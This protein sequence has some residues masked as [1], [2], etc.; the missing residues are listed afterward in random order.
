MRRCLIALLLFLAAVAPALADYPSP[1]FKC[2]SLNNGASEVCP[3][4][5]GAKGDG[6]I[7]F[8]GAVTSTFS[9]ASASGTST[10]SA[11]P[12]ITTATNNAVVVDVFSVAQTYSVTPNFVNSRAAIPWVSGHYGLYAGDQT[13]A[14]AGA[15]SGVS[16]T[17]S[18]SAIWTATRIPL[19]PI[20]ATTISFVNATTYTSTAT[21]PITLNKPTGLAQGDALVLC[22]GNY[23]GTTGPV[24]PTRLTVPTGFQNIVGTVGQTSM[25]LSCWLKIATASEPSTYTV[26]YDFNS[27]SGESAILL[28]YRNVAGPENMSRTLTSASASF[29]N[30]DV[31]KPICVAAVWGPRQEQQACGTIAGVTDSHT[32]TTSFYLPNTATGLQFAYGTDDTAAFQ[33]ML[34][35]PPCNTVGCGV[36][37]G[38]KRYILTDSLTINYDMPFVMKGIAAAVPNNVNNYNFNRLQNLKGGTSLVWLTT[39]LTSPAITFGGGIGRAYVTVSTMWDVSNVT[40]YGGVGMG[41]DGAG[42]VGL[43]LYDVMNLRLS[44]VMVQGFYGDGVSIQKTGTD[45]WTTGIALTQCNIQANGGVGV[46]VGTVLDA[47]NIEATSIT[48][49]TIQS[50]GKANIQLSGSMLEGVTITDNVIQWGNRLLYPSVSEVYVNG[51]VMGG[52]I[53][54]NYFEIDSIQGSASTV[55]LNANAGI[56]GIRT[57]PNYLFPAG[58]STNLPTFSAAGTALPSCSSTD[59]M[60]NRGRATVTD[61]TAAC[62]IG[63][64]YVGGGANRCDVACV[65]GAWTGTGTASY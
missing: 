40:F 48:G 59:A 30:T 32:I 9:G 65:S 60:I 33:T 2:V 3:E 51:K 63:A 45:G 25:N 14:T 56:I 20:P 19:V 7:L 47:A 11:S 22:V 12:A 55:W 21:A 23:N 10:A 43:A 34:T 49:C 42:D 52:V 13:V 53:E 37:L 27:T 62:T 6:V 17:L 44:N 61:M 18:S 5:Y 39:S 1:T 46:K 38:N 16:G 4:S 29:D 35:T 41:M 31:G 8:D 36:A 64:A 57:W 50:N 24:H 15:V 26:T 54:G 28:A 58:A